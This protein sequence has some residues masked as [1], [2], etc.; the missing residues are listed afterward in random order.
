[1]QVLGRTS[2][3]IVMSNAGLSC[4][5]LYATDICPKNHLLTDGHSSQI[6]EFCNAA[7]AAEKLVVHRLTAQRIVSCINT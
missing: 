5:A 4:N 1:M 2:C 6:K 7:A 3:I